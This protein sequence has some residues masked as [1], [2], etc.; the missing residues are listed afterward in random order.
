MV[1]MVADSHIF[2]GWIMIT[3]AGKLKQL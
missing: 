2:E 1:S 3:G